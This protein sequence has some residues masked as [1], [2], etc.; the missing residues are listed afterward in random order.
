M[1]VKE[2][3]NCKYWATDPHGCILDDPKKQEREWL[4]KDF[5]NWDHSLAE[6]C[7]YFETRRNDKAKD[8]DR[9]IEIILN[10]CELFTDEH[11]EAYAAIKF[12][13]C[14]EVMSTRSKGFRKWLGYEFYQEEGRSPSTETLSTAMNTIEGIAIHEGGSYHLS[15]RVSGD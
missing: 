11:D 6:V 3:R 5:E 2:C 9:L 8:A 1:A 15:V 12:G 7:S 10:K 13:G 4:K 14:Y